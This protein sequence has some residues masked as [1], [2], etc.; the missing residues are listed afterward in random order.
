MEEKQ[1][2]L[3][4]NMEKKLMLHPKVRIVDIPQA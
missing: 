1:Q 2:S 3:Q 4:K